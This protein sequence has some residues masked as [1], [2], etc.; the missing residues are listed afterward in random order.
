MHTLAAALVL[1]ATLVPEPARAVRDSYG[2]GSRSFAIASKVLDQ[3]RRV[4]I[5]LPSSFEKTSRRYP[6][7]ILF[8][9][10]FLMQPVVTVADVLTQEGQ[11][12]ESVIVSI[13]NTD[14]YD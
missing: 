11:M 1:A 5:H 10:E 12:P 14:D 8:D 7:V 9:G 3:S 6:T 2:G 13:E 4:F